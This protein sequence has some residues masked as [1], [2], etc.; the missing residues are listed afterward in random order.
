MSNFAGCKCICDDPQ[1]TVTGR[2]GEAAIEVQLQ[3]DNSFIS[4]LTLP[5][6]NHCSQMIH[7]TQV[8]GL[9]LIDKRATDKNYSEIGQLLKDTV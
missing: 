5:G 3:H 6:L 9:L 7:L 2:G 1:A 4:C 8:G